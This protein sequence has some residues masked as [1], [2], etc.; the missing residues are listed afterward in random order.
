MMKK[1]MKKGKNTVLINWGISYALILLVPLITIFANYYHNTAIIKEEIMQA[2]E[3]ILKNLKDSVDRVMEEEREMFLLFSTKEEFQELVNAS[4]MD[5]DFYENAQKFSEQLNDYGQNNNGISYWLYMQGKDYLV[6]NGSGGS[7]RNIYYSQKPYVNGELDFEQWKRLLVDDYSNDFFVCD[8]FYDDY[9]K[10]NLIYA[11]SYHGG[12]RQKANIFVSMPMSVIEELTESLPAGS[13]L[14]VY[15]GDENENIQEQLLILGSD[16]MMKLPE[17]VDITPIVEGELTFEVTD[18]VGISM[19]SENGQTRYSLLVPQATFWNDLRYSRD[20]H[21]VGLLI[22]LVVGIG[23]VYFLLKKNYRP[24]SS[25]LESIGSDDREGDVFQHIQ[26]AYHMMRQENYDMHKTIRIQEKSL[27]SSHLLSMLKGRITGIGEDGQENEWK[28]SFREGGIALVGFYIPTDVNR[29]VKNDELAFFIV[30]NVFSELMET[31]TFYRAEDGRFLYYLFCVPTAQAEHWKEKS[32]KNV[33]FLCEF[34]DEKFGLNLLA[35]IS[36]VEQGVDQVKYIYQNVMEAFEYKRMIGGDGV[37]TTEEL[38]GVFE[39]EQLHDCHVKL[40]Q[41]LEKGDA[42]DAHRISR[43]LFLCTEHT[44][45]MVTRIRVLEAFQIV[46]D[47][48]NTYITNPSKQKQLLSWLDKLLNAGD[49]EN[50]RLTFDEMLTFACDKIG[51]QL[52]TENSGIVKSIREYVEENYTDS[53]LNVNSIAEKMNRNPVY[54]S[55]IYKEETGEGILDYLNTLRVKK[56]QELLRSGGVSV[57]EVGAMV[58]YATTRTFQRNFA[59][60]MGVTPGNY[61]EEAK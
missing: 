6:N 38:Q 19:A 29:T 33:N 61:G 26:T 1:A 50:M 12:E 14:V 36:A 35:A 16:G 21:F 27:L 39:K 49:R 30:D 58:G 45:F 11:N 4:Q 47:C 22:T 53:S 9:G 56:A 2:H 32:L 60:I 20:M 18:Y 5:W 3:L 55:K 31:E 54:I 25:L 24:V 51:A 17:N 10:G 44:P 57:E 41:A 23:L 40:T 13:M 46:V 42:K 43:Q 34:V 52:E 15:F 8:G 7:G 37:I 28:L 59:K 48:Y